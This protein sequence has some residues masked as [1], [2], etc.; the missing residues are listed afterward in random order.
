MNGQPELAA[1][2]LEIARNQLRRWVSLAPNNASA[3]DQLGAALFRNGG[4]EEAIQSF[5]R[6]RELNPALPL[7]DLRLA[8]VFL[9]SGEREKALTHVGSAVESHRDDANVH[10]AAADLMLVMDEDSLSEQHI[11]RSLGLDP[12]N[13]SVKRL[14]A[15]LMRYRGQWQAAADALQILNTK[16]PADFETANLLALTLAEL[17]DVESKQRAL[18]V[19]TVTAQRFDANSRLGRRS[20][21]ALIWAAFVNGQIDAAQCALEQHLNNG[22]RSN[23]ISGDEGYYL[24]R[25]LAEFGRPEVAVKLLSSTATRIG[26]FPK[27]SDAEALLAQLN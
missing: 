20:R 27:R 15:Q 2:Q 22:I 13:L 1:S 25:L 24:S 11:Q 10:A 18:S 16:N 21:I 26:A 14:E 9:M 3:H 4:T 23:E 7:T 6:A 17:D 5:D 19:A 12:N 8:Q